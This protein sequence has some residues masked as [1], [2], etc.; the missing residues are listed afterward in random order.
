MDD[1][2]DYVTHDH[3]NARISEVRLEVKAVEQQGE[4]NFIELRSMFDLIKTAFESLDHNVGKMVANQEQT[5][6]ELTRMNIE[7]IKLSHR[8]DEVEQETADILAQK[9]EYF[10]DVTK[11]VV[12]VIGTIGTVAGVVLTAVLV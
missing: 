1:K 6:N 12:A 7:N 11:I 4:K 2:K 10:S 8:L 5:N 9:K 3:L